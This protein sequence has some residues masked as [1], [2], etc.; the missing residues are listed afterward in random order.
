MDTAIWV[1]ALSIPRDAG[2][3]F[4]QIGVHLNKVT[5]AESQRDGNFLK[6]TVRKCINPWATER[7][8]RKILERFIM[9]PTKVGH[10]ANEVILQAALSVCRC[11]G[12]GNP[13]CVV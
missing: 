1:L 9:D 4:C 2:T 6:P 7:N 13:R 8:G 5:L 10:N 3:R 12:K 11:L